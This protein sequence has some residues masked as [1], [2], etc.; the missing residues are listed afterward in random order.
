MAV[1]PQIPPENPYRKEEIEIEGKRQIPWAWIGI[2]VAL[3]LVGL[4]AW[5][6]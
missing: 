2:V 4:I 3:I 6:I 5:F 1:N